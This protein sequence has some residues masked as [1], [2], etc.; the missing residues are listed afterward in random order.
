[1]SDKTG[2]LLARD[3]KFML[4]RELTL[5]EHFTWTLKK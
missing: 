1:V 3:S 5:R 4:D 2:L